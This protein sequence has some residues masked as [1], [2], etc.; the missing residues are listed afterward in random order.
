MFYSN[1]TIRWSVARLFIAS[2]IA[3]I[4]ISPAQ[5]D[6]TY[7]NKL[8]LTGGVSQVE[9]AAGGGLTHGRSLA[10]MAP[11]TKLAVTFIT[12]TLNRVISI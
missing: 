6:Q 2:A 9:G 12:H 10:A 7:S 4:G 3:A 8:L 1:V 11:I 5:A